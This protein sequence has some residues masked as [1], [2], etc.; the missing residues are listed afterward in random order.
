MHTKFK[1]LLLNIF[2]IKLKKPPVYL[3]SI[4][5]ITFIPYK[6]AILRNE[7]RKASNPQDKRICLVIL[8]SIYNFKINNSQWVCWILLQ[9][10]MYINNSWDTPCN[11]SKCKWENSDFKF[12]RALPTV[13]GDYKGSTGKV[14]LI[15]WMITLCEVKVWKCASLWLLPRLL[16]DFNWL[17]PGFIPEKDG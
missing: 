3:K 17:G 16:F 8:H 15:E 9:G 1:G 5:C 2:K 14:G 11:F 4:Q 6:R 10:N 12:K 7:K 13:R